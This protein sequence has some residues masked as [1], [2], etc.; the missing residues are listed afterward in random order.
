MHKLNHIG[1]GT[2]WYIEYD[3]PVS[4]DDMLKQMI[5]DFDQQYSRFEV[6]SLLHQY[7]RG[8]IGLENDVHL[9]KMITLGHEYETLTEGK[10]SLSV[11]K[12]LVEM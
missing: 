9:T 6:D 12:R 5:T 1:C 10:F 7:Q 2:H 11:G 4:Y 8:E 3:S